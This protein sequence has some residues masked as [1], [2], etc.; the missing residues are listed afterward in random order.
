M[1]AIIQ[2][3]ISRFDLPIFILGISLEKA[4]F[5]C[6]CDCWGGGVAL[7]DLNQITQIIT[8]NKDLFSNEI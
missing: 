2:S 5:R 8:P 1:P 6:V 4:W 7:L 3:E